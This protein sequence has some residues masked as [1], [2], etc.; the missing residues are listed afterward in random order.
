MD[1][2]GVG[3]GRRKKMA[4]LGLWSCHV[5][6]ICASPH[7]HWALLQPIPTPAARPDTNIIPLWYSEASS[8]GQGA[9][10]TSRFSLFH[11]GGSSFG[12]IVLQ[13][14]HEVDGH[15]VYS[16]ENPQMANTTHSLGSVSQ[17]TQQRRAPTISQAGR[18]AQ[19]QT[20]GPGPNW[21]D[22]IKQTI[23]CVGRW[24]VSLNREVTG[25]VR[26]YLQPRLSEGEIDFVKARRP[27]HPREQGL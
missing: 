2:R 25:F 27:S 15:L 6:P 20:S 11:R 5:V 7:S 19:Q 18:P 3:I 9:C 8:S 14:Q 23:P 1:Q 4:P 17:Q 12:K 13:D 16:A 10:S 24:H 21:G 26:F 22:Q